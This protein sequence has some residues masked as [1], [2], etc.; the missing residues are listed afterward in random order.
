MEQ[1]P[2]L[3]LSC[4]STI[5]HVL[6]VSLLTTGLL[7]KSLCPILTKEYLKNKQV[8]GNIK[9]VAVFQWT[10]RG[11]NTYFPEDFFW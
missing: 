3:T 6:V 11:D 5:I 7:Q 10:Q 9:G 4:Y 1:K 2:Q 8:G